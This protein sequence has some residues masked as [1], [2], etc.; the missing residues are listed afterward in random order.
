[1]GILNTTPDSFSDGGKNYGVEDA[2][3]AALGMERA[4]VK[5]IDI[6]GES[7]RPGAPAVSEDDEIQRTVPVVRALREK[8][9]ILISIDTSKAAVAA[10]ALEAGADIVNDV[11]GLTGDPEMIKLCA[12]ARCGVV[13]MHMQGNPRTMQ[14]DPQYDQGVV[15]ELQEFFAERLDTLA[16]AGIDPECISFDPGIGFGK[17]VQQNITLIEHLADLQKQQGRPILLGVSRKSMIGVLTGIEVP[18]DR[19][20]A[21]AVITAL[22]FQRGIMLHRVHNVK[23]NAQALTLA[24]AI[25]S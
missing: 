20:T 24:D 1:M 14:V 7:T 2:V 23:M 18:Q 21:T 15:Q 4:G 8:S 25:Y 12:E 16:G 22:S 19:D 5:I 6:G 10:A 17:T 13:V 11:T 3:H 9:D